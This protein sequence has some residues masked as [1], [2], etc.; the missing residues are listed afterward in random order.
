[1]AV[2]LG[3]SQALAAFKLPLRLLIL[4]RENPYILLNKSRKIFARKSTK[5]WIR[6]KIRQSFLS[7]L[8]VTSQL[9]GKQQFFYLHF[10]LFVSCALLQKLFTFALV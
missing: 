2:C 7:P 10:Y 4:E 5:T 1:M 6:A 3:D 8:P 9:S